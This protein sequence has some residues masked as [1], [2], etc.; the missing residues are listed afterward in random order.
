MSDGR[1]RFL[2]EIATRTGRTFT[3]TIVKF[4]L[5]TGNTR[6]VLFLV[7]HLELE[8][9][10]KKTFDLLLSADIQTVI[11]KEIVLTTLQSLLFI[12]E[13]QQLFLPNDVDLG[14]R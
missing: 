13:Y 14:F 11:D 6:R 8:D 1:D 7:D 4:Y 10:A 2:F 3:A 9:T 12:N 5:T